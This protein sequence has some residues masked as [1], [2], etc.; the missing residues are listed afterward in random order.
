MESY[1]YRAA[2]ASGP[3]IAQPRTT[4]AKFLNLSRQ[5]LRRERYLGTAGHGRVWSPRS[6]AGLI[7]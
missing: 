2:T 3:A 5:N 1:S 7:V 6:V 4:E